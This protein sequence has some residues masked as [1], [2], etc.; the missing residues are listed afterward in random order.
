[1]YHVNNNPVTVVSHT[2]VLFAT[3]A[4]I[5]LIG[6]SGFWCGITLSP[7]FEKSRVPRN[8]VVLAR[9]I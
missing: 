4:M 7:P 9:G 6:L 1:M 8:T 5:F 3:H 2:D